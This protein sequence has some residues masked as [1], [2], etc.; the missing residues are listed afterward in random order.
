MARRVNWLWGLGAMLLAIAAGAGAA[1]WFVGRRGGGGLP[2]GS[3]VVPADALMTI[4]LSTDEAQWKQMRRFGNRDTQSQMNQY[5][6]T[7]RDRLLTDAG[8]DYSED[9]APWVG[10]RITMAFLAAATEGDG[11]DRSEAAPEGETPN[12]FDP[13]LTTLEERGVVWL[14]PIAATG[15][16]GAIA[17]F[18]R[19]ATPEPYRGVDLYQF[20]GGNQSYW[21]ALLDRQL[22]AITLSRGDLEAVIDTDAEAPAVADVPGYQ[23]AIQQVAAPE[24]F[25][26]VYVNSAAAAEVA[27]SSAVSGTPPRLTPLRQDSQGVVATARLTAS[28]VDIDSA[29][30]LKPNAGQAFTGSTVGDVAAHLP[31]EAIAV[32]AGGNLRRLWE[33]LQQD[34]E[35]QGLF[36]AENIRSVVEAFT[37]L[38]VVE[39]LIPWMT[40]DYALALVTPELESTGSATAVTLQIKTGDRA[41][42]E[43]TLTQLD[44]VVRSRYDFQIL[45][46]AVDGVPVVQ[47]TSPFAALQVNRTWVERDRVAITVGESAQ[48][49]TALADSDLFQQAIVFE[50]KPSGYFF[51]NPQRLAALDR[52]LPLPSLPPSLQATA[53]AIRAIGLTTTI[54]SDRVMGFDITVLLEQLED[55][56]TL[57]PPNLGA[58]PSGETEAEGD[59][60]APAGF[61]APQ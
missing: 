10:N 29:T 14:L 60:E 40:D 47:W 17:E 49:G 37:G 6:A 19:N 26:Q 38:S 45:Q 53:S 5:I 7:W 25:M 44:D 57:P 36:S 24:A 8:L 43:R 32:M 1:Y 55:A 58:L 61:T 22:V 52:G 16:A 28:G 18:T 3:Q 41:L 56:G 31:A 48:S 34:E 35:A 23:Q 51:I 59:P 30:W 2:V 4:T 54:P 33:H 12:P 27:A 50:G 42:A 11:L 13:T 21:A 46:N 15:N 39:D 9:V 20:N